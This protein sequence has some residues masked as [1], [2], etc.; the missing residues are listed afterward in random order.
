MLNQKIGGKPHN[1]WFM[2]ENP[3]KID[4]L[5]EIPYFWFRL[6]NEG[7]GFTFSLTPRIHV[8]YISLDI[9]NPPNAW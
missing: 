1:G 3:I 2:M 9:Q 4:D 7:V 6:I 5:G 8:C